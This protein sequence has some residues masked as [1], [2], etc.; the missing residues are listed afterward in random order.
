MKM[1]KIKN[2]K[3]NNNLI[4]KNRL[5]RDLNAWTNE[6]GI[7]DKIRNLIVPLKD[8]RVKDNANSRLTYINI[9]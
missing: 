2:K 7:L 4:S 6:T 9:G 8:L 5:K 1:K 3:R